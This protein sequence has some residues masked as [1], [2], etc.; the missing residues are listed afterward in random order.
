MSWKEFNKHH[1]NNQPGTNKGETMAKRV[2]RSKKKLS[3]VRCVY[4]K[5]NEWDVGDVLIGKF[6]SQSEDSYGKP[7][8]AIEVLD[9]QLGDKKAAKKMIDGKVIGLNSTGSLDRAMKKAE[10]GKTY[11]FIYEGLERMDGGPYKGKDKHLIEVEEV[12]EDDGSEEEE[13][14][15]DEEDES[16]YDDL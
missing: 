2:F 11:Q 6:I 7:N 15:E 5:W 16:D 8:Y 10:T 12:T 4:R 13:E 3:S 14:H 1:G 9:V